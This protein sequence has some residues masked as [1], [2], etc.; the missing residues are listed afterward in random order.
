MTPARA[1]LAAVRAAHVALGAALDGLEAALGDDQADELLDL[2]AAA[3]RYGLTSS[4]LRRWARTG[5]L[6]AVE[7]ERGRVAC[8]RSALVEAINAAPYQAPVRAVAVAPDPDT[9][10]DLLELALDAGEL[11]AGGAR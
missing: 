3:E 1:A 8:W 10:E 11:R 2:D 4:T 9:G 7:L 5:R 6:R